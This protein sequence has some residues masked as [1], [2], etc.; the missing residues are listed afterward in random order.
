VK[1]YP[2]EW[3]LYDLDADRTELNDLAAKE[4]QRVQE[5]AKQYDA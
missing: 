5:M 2:R 4:P 3:G 1:W